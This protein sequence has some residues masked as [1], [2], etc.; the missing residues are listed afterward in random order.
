MYWWALPQFEDSKIANCIAK[1]SKPYMKNIFRK[2]VEKLR[3]PVQQSGTNDDNPDAQYQLGLTYEEGNGV[4]QDDAQ[5]VYWYRKA[6]EQGHALAQ[7]NLASMYWTGRGVTQDDVQS[8]AWLQKAAEQGLSSAQGALGTFYAGGRGVA[9]DD[10]QAVSWLHKAAE[11]GDVMAQAD[12][13]TM[14]RLG[15]GVAQSDVQAA[16]WWRQ[17]AEQGDAKSQ[18]NLADMYSAGQGVAQDSIQAAILWRKAAEQGHV[19]AQ[20][21]LAACYFQGD[22]VAQDDAQAAVWWRKA[23]EQGHDVSQ[24]NLGSLYMEGRGVDK[25]D[26]QAAAWWRKAAA[27]GNEK[28]QSDL[29]VLHII[30]QG[31]IAGAVEWLREA[32]EEGDT[33]AKEALMPDA[34]HSAVGGIESLVLDGTTY[35]FGFDF[36]SDL[37][38]SPLFD[39]IDA[40]AAYASVYMLQ[41]DGAHDA[42]YWRELAT[43]AIEESELASSLEERTFSSQVLTLTLE[44]LHHACQNHATVPGFSIEYHLLYLLEAAGGWGVDRGDIE[45]DI[46]IIAGE[47]PLAEGESIAQ[48]AQRLQTRLKALVERASGNWSVLF[49]ALSLNEISAGTSD[50][51]E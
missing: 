24:A 39:D 3:R 31:D 20:A 16:A 51:G 22:G 27:Q 17:A 23:A 29:E 12:L 46:G 6:A 44:K 28:A 43:E 1:A 18:S 5:A 21:S 15:R 19:T 38:L 4:A 35:F 10:V 2:I 45:A 9:Q 40:M 41:A 48:V 26:D 42:A 32:A 33:D 37:V 30:Q 36:K 34:W 8:A 47:Q 7:S 50:Q 25:D 13:G 11:Q 14:F 49:A